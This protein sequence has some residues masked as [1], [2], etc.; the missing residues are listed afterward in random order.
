MSILQRPRYALQSW[1]KLV[2][3]R[4]LPPRRPWWPLS[5]VA[6]YAVLASAAV[7]RAVLRPDDPLVDL[8][9]IAYFAAGL[10]VVIAE[11]RGAS[12]T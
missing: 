10:G 3:P 7:L 8:L 9:V 2:A 5:R 1:R 6:F 4:W 12:L 11:P